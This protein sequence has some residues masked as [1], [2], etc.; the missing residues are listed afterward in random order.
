VGVLL[1]CVAYFNVKVQFVVLSVAF[2]I[3]ILS[4][5]I[6]NV[7][8]LSVGVPLRLDFVFLCQPGASFLN[9]INVNFLL[10]TLVRLGILRH[11]TKVL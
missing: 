5:S 3:I 8:I 11:N 2:C 9:F 4:V 7:V 10:K 1:C 6:L